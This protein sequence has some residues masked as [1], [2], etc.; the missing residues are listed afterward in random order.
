[1]SYKLRTTGIAA[2]LAAAVMAGGSGGAMA[3]APESS[4]PIK[5]ALFDWTS[6]NINANILGNILR[7]SATTS[8]M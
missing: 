5:I 2:A 8:S 6:V 7:S 1:M 3:A 4:D